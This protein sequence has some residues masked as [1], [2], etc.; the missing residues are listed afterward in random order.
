MRMSRE[1]DETL[2]AVLAALGMLAA[3]CFFGAG[4]DWAKRQNSEPWVSG[5]NIER[6]AKTFP[7][8]SDHWEYEK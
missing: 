5:P 8:L 7:E 2:Y 4:A 6:P 3:F 1:A